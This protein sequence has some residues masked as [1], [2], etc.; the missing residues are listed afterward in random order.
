M[1]SKVN[2]RLENTNYTDKTFVKMIVFL[3]PQ[4]FEICRGKINTNP[5][6]PLCSSSSTSTGVRFIKE[7]KSFGTT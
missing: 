5:K 7:T 3:H 1:K 4:G 6:K 2:L